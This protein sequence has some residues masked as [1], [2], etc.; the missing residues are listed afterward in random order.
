MKS[1]KVIYIPR[2]YEAKYKNPDGTETSINL[3]PNREYLITLNNGEKFYTTIASVSKDKAL[4]GKQKITLGI[5]LEP[6]FM[7]VMENDGVEVYMEDVCSIEPMHAKLIKDF[8][9]YKKGGTPR[10]KGEFFTFAFNTAKFDTPYKITVY[11]G[12]FVSMVVAN[13]DSEKG[14]DVIYGTINNIDDNDNIIATRY[15]N[16]KGIRTVEENYVFP[17]KSLLGIY[18]YRL[19]IEPYDENAPRRFSKEQNAEKATNGETNKE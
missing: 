13:P 15:V 19:E 7:N 9:N 17:S 2:G 18:R 4:D 6:G 10:P 16:T 11:A 5:N 8:R 3:R 12:E 14:R 1:N